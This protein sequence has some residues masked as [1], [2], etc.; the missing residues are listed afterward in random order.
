MAEMGDQSKIDMKKIKLYLI[1]K[2]NMK[3]KNSV[4]LSSLSFLA[5]YLFK[6]QITRRL[7][8]HGTK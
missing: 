1:E 8:M 4:S 6:S 7:T 3:M 5:S 2:I